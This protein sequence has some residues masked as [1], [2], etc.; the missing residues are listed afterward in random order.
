MS[1]PMTPSKQRPLARIGVRVSERGGRALGGKAGRRAY[2]DDDQRDK[3]AAIA[4][5]FG[6]DV[7]QFFEEIDTS[8]TLPLAQ[9]PHLEDALQAMERG[10]IHAIVFPYR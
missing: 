4:H 3:G 1:H 6:L 10:E 9:R 8:G 7:E 2:T 5:E